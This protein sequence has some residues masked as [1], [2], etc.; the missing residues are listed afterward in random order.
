MRVILFLAKLDIYV[1]LRYYINGGRAGRPVRGPV[2][3]KGARKKLL[4]TTDRLTNGPN[5]LLN[6][7][8]RKKSVT[9][10]QVQSQVQGSIY[11]QGAHRGQQQLRNVLHI[12]MQSRE[13][14]P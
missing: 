10:P 8:L 2:E 3:R 13:Y 14:T 9:T 4:N 7:A 12:H 6:P 5:R 11:S 1:N